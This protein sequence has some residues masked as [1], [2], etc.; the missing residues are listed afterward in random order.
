MI[1]VSLSPLPESVVN[2][3]N[4]V[5][6]YWIAIENLVRCKLNSKFDAGPPFFLL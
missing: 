6:P 4:I 2:I 1:E 3:N 5:G